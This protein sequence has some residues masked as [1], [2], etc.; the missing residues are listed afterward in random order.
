[1]TA[2]NSA[3]LVVAAQ[4]RTQDTRRRAVE[5]LRRCDAGGEAVTFTGIA[6]AAG[7]SRS[8][9]YRQADIRGEIDRL[10]TNHPTTA[11]SVPSAQRASTDSLRRRLEA[12][13]DENRRL[14]AENRRLR[15]QLARHLGQRRADGSV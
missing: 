2:A 15:E 5:A 13:L 8:W 9:L 10:R 11:I 14:T 12:S 6:H 7:V 3:A 1:M 4:Q